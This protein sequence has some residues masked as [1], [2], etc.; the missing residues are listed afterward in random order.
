MRRKEIEEKIKGNLD[1]FGAFV[2][3]DE[4]TIKFPPYYH[5]LWWT[6]VEHLQ[7]DQ[8]KKLALGLP[9]GYAKTTIIKLFV[10]FVIAFRLSRYVLVVCATEDRARDFLMDI[11]AIIRTNNFRNM[12]FK[13]EDYL[14]VDTKESKEY[15][16]EDKYFVIQAVGAGTAV[17]GLNKYSM[18]PELIILDDAQTREN[19]ESPAASQALF[20]WVFATLMKTV[21]PKKYLVV[22]VGN[23][24]NEGCILNKLKDSSEWVSLI[25]GAILDDGESIWPEYRS[26]D[27][28]KEEYLHDSS[29]GAG[30]LFFAECQN[31]VIN[32]SEGTMLHGCRWETEDVNEYLIE[33]SFIVIDPADHKINSDKHGIVVCSVIDGIGFIRKI[34]NRVMSPGECIDETI[35][36]VLD[37]GI[38]CVAIES[39][40]YQGTLG[41]W[42]KEKL[43]EQ[44]LGKGVT[45]VDVKPG[46]RHKN[47]RLV[48]WLRAYF[49]KFYEVERSEDL[50]VIEWQA[51][52]F[53][54][55]KTN[56]E[57]DVLDACAYCD[58]VIKE[59]RHVWMT[60][61]KVNDQEVIGKLIKGVTMSDLRARAYQ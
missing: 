53:D 17:R 42:L 14:I 22:W 40:A 39:V 26:I 60:T 34:V 11:D 41:Y 57:D 31:I 20:N 19:S 21:N 36:L 32:V 23:M 9:R 46:N 27:N 49:D 51:K 25:T 50:A 55:T 15:K 56:N 2:L 44:G 30:N 38:G 58:D 52:K 13:I 43:D 16:I 6:M 18:R 3:P 5:W 12:F 4:I 8:R 47:K 37:Y 29:V 35:K 45:V 54:I 24:Y 48:T 61:R 33:G 59:H 10:V 1:Y 28:I 7:G